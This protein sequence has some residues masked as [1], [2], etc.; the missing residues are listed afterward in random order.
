MEELAL[1]IPNI[2]EIEANKPKEKLPPEAVLVAEANETLN[3][4]DQQVI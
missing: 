4:A 2:R 1:K 3:L